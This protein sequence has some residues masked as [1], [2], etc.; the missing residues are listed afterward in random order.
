MHILYIWY[1]AEIMK[2][3]IE[4]DVKNEKVIVKGMI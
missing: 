4:L 2:G 1:L 3:M